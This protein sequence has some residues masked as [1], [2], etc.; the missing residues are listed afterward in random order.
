MSGAGRT[1]HSRHVYSEMKEK[2]IDL[3][4]TAS[5]FACC[6]VCL[7]NNEWLMHIPETQHGGID[8][9]KEMTVI[10]KISRKLHKIIWLQRGDVV[11]INKNSL[12]ESI[13][14]R[15]RLNGTELFA[16]RKKDASARGR[17]T[18]WERS[19]QGL[20]VDELK[21]DPQKHIFDTADQHF[22]M[23]DRKVTSSQLRQFHREFSE[24]HSADTEELENS[25]PLCDASILFGEAN[26]WKVP[27][28]YF[29]LLA[30]WNGGLLSHRHATDCSSTRAD[31]SIVYGGSVSTG[32]EIDTSSDSD[33]SEV[34]TE[35]SHDSTEGARS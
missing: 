20:C 27:K 10:G 30:A 9:P 17:K 35:A 23:I 13:E 6:S 15:K 26:H 28:H 22:V 4:D 16:T 31:R 3:S 25:F 1:H 12:L 24:P 18:S 14:E 7:G 11:Q 29:E 34:D 19:F 32:W 33:C 21:V 2:S 5:L 8:L